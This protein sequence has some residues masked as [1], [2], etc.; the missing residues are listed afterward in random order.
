MK[1]FKDF[2][3]RAA[4]HWFKNTQASN[5]QDVRIYEFVRTHLSRS[6]RVTLH[7][8]LNGIANL[9][10]EKPLIAMFTYPERPIMPKVWG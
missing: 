2:G 1:V 3:K 9:E 8:H 10:Q 7:E 4:K 6:F 5:L